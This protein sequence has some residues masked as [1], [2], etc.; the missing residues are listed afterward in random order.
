MKLADLL[1][2]NPFGSKERGKMEI[3]QASTEM[4][5]TGAEV[6]KSIFQVMT[7]FSKIWTLRFLSLKMPWHSYLTT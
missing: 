1:E 7:E 6:A 3:E 2:K 4:G 5:K